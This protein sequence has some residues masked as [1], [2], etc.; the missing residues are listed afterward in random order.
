MPIF[1]NSEKQELGWIVI[2]KAVAKVKQN[3]LG[4]TRTAKDY[5]SEKM[6]ERYLQMLTGLPCE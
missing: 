2:Q 4:H 6:A 5:K 3:Y 1:A